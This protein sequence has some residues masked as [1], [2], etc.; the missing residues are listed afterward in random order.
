MRPATT[1]LLVLLAGISCGAPP[2]VPETPAAAPTPRGRLQ[3]AALARLDGEGPKG[4]IGRADRAWSPP[5]GADL[6]GAARAWVERFGP[7]RGVAAPARR[8]LVEARRVPLRSGGGVVTFTSWVDGAPVLDGDVSVLLGAD[9]RP[10]AWSVGTAF[11]PGLGSRDDV[12]IGADDAL[13]EVLAD[14]FDVA[15]V[16]GEVADRGIRPDGWT[17]LSWVGAGVRLTRPARARRVWWPEGDRLRPAWQVEV[18]AE[19]GGASSTWELVVAGDDGSVLRRRDRQSDAFTWRVYA[20]ASGTYTPADSP[21]EDVTPHP[22]GTPD[23][24]VADLAD[25]VLVTLDSLS[26]TADPWLDAAATETTG[27]N[28]D[29]YV[30]YDGADGYTSGDFRAD[31]TSAGTFDRTYDETLEPTA[32][33]EQGKASVTHAFYVTNWLHDW[34]YDAGFTETAGNAQLSNYGRGG[35][36]GDPLHVEVQDN[37]F[38]GSRDNANMSTPADGEPPTMQMYLWSSPGDGLPEVDGGLDTTVVAHEW[39]HFLHLRLA[40]CGELQCYGMSEGWGDFVALHLMLRD[41]DDLGGAY[42]VAAYAYASRGVDPLYYGVRRAPYSTDPAFNALSF[43][44]ISAGEALPATHPLADNYNGNAEVHNAGEIWASVLFDAY[45]ALQEGRDASES[46]ED[47]QWR[48]S[49]IVV[50]GLALTPS[51]ATYTEARDALLA[52]AA[53]IDPGDAALMADAFAGR[54][55]GSCAVSPASDSADLTGVVEDTTLSPALGL[56]A[57][58][59]RD[60]ERSCDD[61]GILDAGERG[62]LTL[63]VTNSGAADLVGAELVVSADLAGVTF[64]DGATHLLADLGPWESVDVEIA[65]D[66][67]RAVTTVSEAVV[68]ATLVAADA[69]VTELSVALGA[70]VQADA[71]S[72]GAATDGFDVDDG[73]WT[74]DGTDADEIWARTPAEPVEFS[75]I[76]VDVSGITDTRL[77]TPSMLASASSPLV[78]AFSN[79]YSFEAS[80]GYFWDGGVLEVSV[81]GGD[82]QDVSA[83]VDPGYGGT[84]T[85]IADNPLGDR[86]GFVATNAS[87]PAMDRTTLDLGT[88]LAGSHVRFSFRIGTDQALGDFGWEIDDVA[89]TGIDDTPFP[90]LVAQVDPCNPAPVADAGPDQEVDA[91]ATVA[92]DGSASADPWE[93]PVTYTWTEQTTGGLVLSDTTVAAPSFSAPSVT[94]DTTYTLQLTVD[95]GVSSASDTVDVLVVAP[96]VDTDTGGDSAVDTAPEGDTDTDVVADA[97]PVEKDGGCGCATGSSG[98][99]GAAF[100]A[101]LLAAARRRRR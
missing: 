39:G 18:F 55:M 75:W 66:L 94:E 51:E 2:P 59:Y 36:E 101:L 17:S 87:W 11:G 15:A 42:P 64:P 40:S 83:W 48:M 67:D 21:Y 52:A 33:D 27:N 81:E 74:V 53:A 26:A 31:L 34:Y 45:V 57:P 14:R 24:T 73:S 44:H 88:A 98:V 20:D 84:I 78:L 70:H 68:G 38:G 13:V 65:V 23:G 76:G 37:A 93:D 8:T 90:A 99:G 30:D 35:A 9:L 100:G 72:A 92:L 22:T 25:P 12:R 69:C 82:W 85:T 43:R 96:Q 97:D 95:D 60:G 80:D 5:P 3:A 71:V 63:T 16:P 4:R 62:I 77:V 32:S 91:G 50:A 28:V 29:A 7:S 56:D 41:G 19:R 89:I 61:D 49:E 46:F 1:A 54:G 10:V 58:I 47:I 86:A 79:R 6:P